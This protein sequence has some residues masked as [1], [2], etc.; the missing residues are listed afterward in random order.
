MELAILNPQNVIKK[1]ESKLLLTMNLPVVSRVFGKQ[2]WNRTLRSGSNQVLLSN[3]SMPLSTAGETNAL[4][5]LGG[6]RFGSPPLGEGL[7]AG[8]GP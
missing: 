7:G 8:V 3:F 4:L 2:F 5:S 6:R 1:N